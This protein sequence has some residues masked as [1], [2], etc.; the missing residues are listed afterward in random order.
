MYVLR[1]SQTMCIIRL[2][3]R[4]VKLRKRKLQI[5]LNNLM[6]PEIEILYNLLAS[7]IMFA[8]IISNRLTT[9]YCI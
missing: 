7:H 9:L 8:F 1:Y 6:M 2:L 3:H 5:V 4:I